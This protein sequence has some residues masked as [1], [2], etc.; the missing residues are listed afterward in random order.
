M[1]YA[2]KVVPVYRYPSGAKLRFGKGEQER[3]VDIHFFENMLIDLIDRTKLRIADYF[4]RMD[5][6]PFFLLAATGLGKTVGVPTHALLRGCERHLKN[7]APDSIVD[8]I[9]RVWI[10]VP[11]IMIAEDLVDGM[12]RM[13]ADYWRRTYPDSFEATFG[14]Q[15][16]DKEKALFDA[17]QIGF[18]GC[19]SKNGP[20]NPDAPIMFITTGLLWI[21]VKS[22]ELV[23]G[24][25]RIIIDEAHVTIE[26]A[27]EVEIAIALARYHNIV[28]DYM[29]ATVD[30]EGLE[31]R[32]GVDL[33]RADQ[34]RF[35]IWMHN[36]RQTAE[37]SVVRLVKNTIIEPNPN[38]EF[39]PKPDY[40]DCQAVMDGVLD[41]K[42]R[43]RGLLIMVNSYK[44]EN[45]DINKLKRLIEAANFTRDSKSLRVLALAGDIIRNQVQKDEFYRELKN[46]QLECAPFVVIATSVVEMGITFPNLDFVATMNSGFREQCFDGQVV[47]GKT[48]LGINA[49]MQRV[50]RVGR[51]YPGIAYIFKEVESGYAKLDDVALNNGGLVN[52]PIRFP[53]AY[54]PLTTLAL[55]LIA[56]EAKNGD[57]DILQKMSFPSRCFEGLIEVEE[58]AY[59][60]DE[61]E[62]EVNRFPDLLAE[63][64]RLFQLGIFPPRPLLQDDVQAWNEYRRNIVAQANIYERWAGE[65]DLAYVQQLQEAI[66]AEEPEREDML[67]WLV[68]TACSKTGISDLTYG[69]KLPR[70]DEDWDKA[71]LQLYRRDEL[72]ALYELV[73]FTIDH[74]LNPEGS[75]EEQAQKLA[76]YDEVCQEM[77]F[78]QDKLEELVAR[79]QAALDDYLK[80]HRNTK[81]ATN[82][83]KT[84][85]GR[86]RDLNVLN[87]RWPDICEEQKNG[88]RIPVISLNYD[89]SHPFRRT[90]VRMTL[91]GR[92]EWE[93]VVQ[94]FLEEDQQS[95]DVEEAVANDISVWR[96]KYQRGEFIPRFTFP[97][98]S[99]V[100]FAK[101]RVYT[102]KKRIRI[103]PRNGRLVRELIHIASID[104]WKPS[105]DIDE[106]DD[107]T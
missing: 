23:P 93:E 70:T 62:R 98:V 57:V 27:P 41:G 60:G 107:N 92:P 83:L 99:T 84:I 14:R 88:Q 24:R 7:V 71:P 32:L 28:V 58:E 106:D 81:G 67:F 75:F 40:P 18:Y 37:D 11:R 94:D 80:N 49:L 44:G 66:E 86:T 6:N 78:R 17:K 55:Y 51:I 33:I 90:A 76:Q 102:G 73:Q 63:Q 3:I 64:A 53:L 2:Q 16:T 95:D 47:S 79:V 20:V 69:G 30:T 8:D 25:D 45:S 26:Q 35:P 1:S 65:Y 9:P 61:A 48:V 103:D 77:G 87:M 54:G 19:I 52:E 74:K 43:S 56:H 59:H 104:R 5:Q 13:V 82:G 101:R 31:E 22:G 97:H 96:K 15:E 38:S 46:A 29:S 85:F 89:Q 42:T 36:L 72:I 34:R 68:A 91:R 50:G 21:K 100:R 12:N 4:K 39:F 10:V 105:D